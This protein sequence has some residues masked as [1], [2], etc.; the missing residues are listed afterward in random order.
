MLRQS[1]LTQILN[2][3]MSTGKYG[4]VQNSAPPKRSCSV[5]DTINELSLIN[6]K[7]L[8]FCIPLATLFTRYKSMGF[9]SLRSCERFHLQEED[10][11]S[12]QPQKV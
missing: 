3:G 11:R 2:R 9:P 10:D 1:I 12:Y 6:T 5:F 8:S 7:Q 4:S